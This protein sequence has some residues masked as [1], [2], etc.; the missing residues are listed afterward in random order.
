MVEDDESI[1]RALPNFFP[2]M[3]VLDSFGHV[4]R[5]THSSHFASRPFNSS[6]Y[7][8]L[9]FYKK[10]S[11]GPL[12]NKRIRAISFGVEAYDVITTFQASDSV[13]LVELF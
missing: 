3:A 7:F 13:P 6:A 4:C 10:D 1:N 9:V 5:N 11:P 12:H 2:S 8:F